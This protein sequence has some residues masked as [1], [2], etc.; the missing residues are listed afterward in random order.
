[1]QLLGALFNTLLA[2]ILIAGALALT[3]LLAYGN[4]RPHPE[5]ERDEELT[6]RA[7]EH[8]GMSLMSLAVMGLSQMQENI[9]AHFI[10]LIAGMVAGRIHIKRFVETLSKRSGPDRT[11]GS[12]GER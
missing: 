5:P 1:M 3:G 10:L 11:K 4:L 9:L 6:S 12:G 7:W 8:Y 2:I